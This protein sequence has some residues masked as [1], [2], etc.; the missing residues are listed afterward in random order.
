[1]PHRKQCGN[2]TSWDFFY[3]VAMAVACL[4]AYWIMT[5]GLARLVDTP[6]DLLGGMW[7]VAATV[8]VFRET[9]A[10][11]LSAGIS[12]LIATCV[13][14]SLCLSYLWIFPFTAEGMAVLLGVGTLA[15][16]LLDRREEI[17][18]TAI[19]TTV[20]MVVAAISPQGS[21]HQ[22]LLRLVDTLVGIGVG[23]SFRWIASFLF[24]RFAGNPVR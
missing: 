20:V 15:M 24:Y 2:L 18:T 3:S 21:W 7:A 9:R 12:R 13:S 23:I 22:P 17:V 19:T 10:E 4:I 8:F 1:M 14:F 6:D 5:Y 11:S 16:A